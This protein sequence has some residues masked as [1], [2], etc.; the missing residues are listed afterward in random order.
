MAKNK[1]LT[2]VNLKKSHVQVGSFLNFPDGQ[3][4]SFSSEETFSAWSMCP[5]SCKDRPVPKRYRW[6]SHGTVQHED[7]A[8]STAECRK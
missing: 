5:A 7:C 1:L 2:R 4:I 6:S 8:K 3:K